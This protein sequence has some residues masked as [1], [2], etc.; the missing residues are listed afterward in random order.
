MNLLDYIIILVMVYLLVRGVFRGFVREIASL[1]GIILGFITA[2]IYFPDLSDYLKPYIPS[3]KLVPFISIVIIFFFV[4]I[5]CNLIG[6]GLWLLLKK[7][8][9]GWLDRGLGAGFAVLKG[10]LII[11]MAMV[12]LTVFLPVRAPLIAESMLAPYVIKSYQS[13]I[14][15]VS[16]D[17]FKRC[18]DIIFG[19]F[20]K[21]DS[22]KQGN[23]GEKSN[24]DG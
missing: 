7:M 20:Q 15:I 23:T 18:K 11:Y 1:L 19:E 22:P 21:P 24:K 8:F 14:G 5:I 17:F 2:L 16:P 4:L 12:L 13:V 3:A 6:W 9:F 10:I